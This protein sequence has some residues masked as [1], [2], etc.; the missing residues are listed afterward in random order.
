MVSTG[1]GGGG[2]GG[3]GEL[4]PLQADSPAKDIKRIIMLRKYLFMNTALPPCFSGLFEAVYWF[5]IEV[6]GSGSH[7][8]LVASEIA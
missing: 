7:M 8:G 3:G 6:V 2:D 4:P 1:G 5:D